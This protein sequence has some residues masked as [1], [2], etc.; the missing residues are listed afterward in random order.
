MHYA[1]IQDEKRDVLWRG[2]VSVTKEGFLSL[3]EKIRTIGRSNSKEIA[4]IFM[5]PT[6]N[7]HITLKYFLEQNG[8]IGMIHLIDARRTVH[9]RKIM[10]L[11]K[12]KSDPEDAHVL[13]ATPFVDRSSL[14]RRD[15]ERSPLSEVTREREIILRNVTR[16]SNHIQADLNVVFPE[17]PSIMSIDS[18]TGMAILEK[19]TTPEN[20]SG[21]DPEK[22]LKFMQKNGRNHFK[23]EDAQNIIEQAMKSVGIPDV[24]GTYSFRLRMNVQRLGSE[25]SALKCVEKEIEFR[26]E[27]N[28][29]IGHLREMKGIGAVNAAVIVSEI[30]NIGQFDSALKLQSYGGKCPD[31]SGSGGKVRATGITR[32]RNSHLSNAVHESAVS[33]VVHRNHEF[34]ELF[35]RETMK[36]K[37]RTEAYVVVGK[38]LLFHVYGIMKNAKPYRERKPG[39]TGGGSVPMEA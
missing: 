9:L 25:L 11:G 19:Y 6:G 27:G 34:Y 8:F 2:R 29:H 23:L 20:I 13:A 12:E 37:S 16:I 18:K 28:E 31:M 39:N 7:Y 4:G 38:R 15:H 33:L 3:V 1:E 22:L 30:G 10:N 32:T 26:S 21:L 24:E 14:E 5:N 17:F 35:S 36:K